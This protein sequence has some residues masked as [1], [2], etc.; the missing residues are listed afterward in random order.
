MLVAR[1]K[2]QFMNTVKGSR[3]FEY[4]GEGAFFSRVDQALAYSWDQ[5][6]ERYDDYD[7]ETCPLNNYIK[8]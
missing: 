7:R 3:L 6:E 5:L 8:P 4:M 2:R 1:M